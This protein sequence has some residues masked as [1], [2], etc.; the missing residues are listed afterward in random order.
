MADGNTNTSSVFKC[1]GVVPLVDRR[2]TCEC[3]TVGWPSI[4]R[5]D[6]Q[7]FSPDR[8]RLSPKN[9]ISNILHQL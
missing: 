8:C 6:R 9:E 2:V 5:S 4:V 1:G 7:Q 3:G